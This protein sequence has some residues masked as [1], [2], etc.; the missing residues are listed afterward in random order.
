MDFQYQFNELNDM[1][2]NYFNIMQKIAMCITDSIYIP[3]HVYI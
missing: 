3:V 2:H 1:L